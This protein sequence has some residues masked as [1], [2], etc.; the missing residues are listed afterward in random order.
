M[1]TSHSPP[2]SF[3]SHSSRFP[4]LPQRVL[5]FPLPAPLLL[6][7]VLYFLP[8][9]FGVFPLLLAAICFLWPGQEKPGDFMG[10]AV[11]PSGEGGGDVNTYVIILVSLTLWGAQASGLVPANIICTSPPPNPETIQP[12]PHLHP[13]C[14]GF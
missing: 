2:S 4:C 8:H 12:H 6:L 3:L 9:L 7:Q 13:D 1:K 10:I 14:R 11:F 5:I